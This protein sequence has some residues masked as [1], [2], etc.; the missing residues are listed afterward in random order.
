MK[1]V[2]LGTDSLVLCWLC[3]QRG[4][5]SKLATISEAPVKEAVIR[6]LNA[7]PRSD[8]LKNATWE[9]VKHVNQPRLLTFFKIPF[10]DDKEFTHALVRLHTVQVR[11]FP[12]SARRVCPYVLPFLAIRLIREQRV[13][14]PAGKK[15]QPPVVREQTLVENLLFERRDWLRAATGK[16]GAWWGAD[17]FYKGAPYKLKRVVEEYDDVAMGSEA[18][19]KPISDEEMKGF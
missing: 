8:R 2:R 14:V 18:L 10:F 15:N 13:T 4:D 3:E 7:R 6:S 17:S 1:H 5:T 19:S 9:I 12:S 16:S 11:L